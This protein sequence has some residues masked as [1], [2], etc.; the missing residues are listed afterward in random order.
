LIAG[1]LVNSLVASEEKF[2]TGLLLL[3]V[4]L[5]LKNAQERKQVNSV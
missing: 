4:E 2:R 3:C 5:V 1:Q